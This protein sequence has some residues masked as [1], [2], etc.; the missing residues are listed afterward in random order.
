MESE[1]VVIFNDTGLHARPAS[2][3]VNTA[4]KFKADL[5]I[6]KGEKKVN[7]KSILSV[8]GL[9]IAKGSEITLSADGP[10]EKEAISKLI[11]LIR[12]GFNE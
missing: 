8:L 2:I 5:T 7:A 1:K 9:G 11:E 12:S 6:A 3:F 10:D 4:A